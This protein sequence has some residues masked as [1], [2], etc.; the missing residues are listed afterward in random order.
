MKDIKKSTTWTSCLCKTE[1]MLLPIHPKHIE[2]IF[3]GT[4]Q[5]EF[6]KV[7]CKDNVKSILMYATSPQKQVVGEA[8]ICE[9]LEGD[10]L[11]I[12]KETKEYA[13]ISYDYFCSYYKDKKV[14]IA[15]KLTNV[16]MYEKPLSL[17]NFGIKFAPQ[18]FVYLK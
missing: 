7:R 11:S 4:K 17:E 2:K 12:W 10:L 6:R 8:E 9:I 3:E 14:A 1:K 16:I 18:S 15:Y 5:Y 13:G